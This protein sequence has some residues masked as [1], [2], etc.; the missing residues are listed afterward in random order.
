VVTI[1]DDN[2]GCRRLLLARQLCTLN[3]DSLFLPL[4]LVEKPVTYVAVSQ[5]FVKVGWKSAFPTN[6]IIQ[7][8]KLVP[9]MMKREK[10]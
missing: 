4:N 6:K 10:R 5:H 1:D 8:R 3:A 7:V 2:N 9:K